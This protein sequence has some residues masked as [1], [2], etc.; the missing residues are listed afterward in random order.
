M[1]CSYFPYQ[2]ESLSIFLV[3]QTVDLRLEQIRTSLEKFKVSIDAEA[4][5]SRP[6]SNA[7][8]KPEQDRSEPPNKE[9]L[10]KG[11]LDVLKTEPKCEISH[12]QENK[13]ASTVLIWELSALLGRSKERLRAPYITF[14]TT[15]DL[16]ASPSLTGEDPNDPYLPSLVS[17]PVNLLEG[18]NA[19]TDLEVS[20][21]ADRL[22][23]FFPSLDSG[24]KSGALKIKVEKLRQYKILPALTARIRYTKLDATS[25]QLALAAALDVEMAPGLPN[26]ISI[27][28]VDLR[29]AS[30]IAEDL[31]AN[32]FPPGPKQCHSRDIVGYI[33]RLVPKTGGHITTLTNLNRRS[34]ILETRRGLDIT[35]I[36]TVT[37]S[38]S[39]IPKIEMRWH[40]EVDSS[41]ILHPYPNL[42]GQHTMSLKRL[43]EN[44]GANTASPSKS[45]LQQS[46]STR[47]SYSKSSM[48]SR[49]ALTITFTAPEEPLFAGKPFKWNI[50]VVNHSLESR[51]LTIGLTPTPPSSSSVTAKKHSIK[52]SNASTSTD[53]PPPTSSTN[54]ADK[55]N[56]SATNNYIDY[57]SPEVI[58]LSTDLKIGPLTQGACQEVVMKL[59]PLKAGV[60]R[61]EGVR[62][63]D[64]GREEFVDVRRGDLPDVL[65][66]EQEGEKKEEEEEE[67]G[68]E[69]EEEED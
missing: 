22:T 21:P 55:P 54:T 28:S 65:V 14:R 45:T 2:D 33:Y 59:L 5:E 12:P 20:L 31:G 52:G 23:N 10:W 6:Q 58:A 48:T 60:L 24:S 42:Q 67:E 37:T 63:V 62:I 16:K 41:P 36:A 27:D 38:P 9:T 43:S 68:E 46:A 64:V 1:I 15:V 18:L 39:C 13:P 3:L 35:I 53:A 30:G 19:I 44:T 66:E 4:I 40:T 29:L 56:N 26:G 11:S 51:K 8:G 34:Q 61:L 47:Q 49:F 17:P 25:G 32:I 69:G 7:A 50:L 57:P